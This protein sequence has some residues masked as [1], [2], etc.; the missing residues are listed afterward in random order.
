MNPLARPLA[1]ER[2][3][4]AEQKALAAAAIGAL[5][6]GIACNTGTPLEKLVEIMIAPVSGT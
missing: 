2:L 4:E 1:G 3:S 5:T 6:I